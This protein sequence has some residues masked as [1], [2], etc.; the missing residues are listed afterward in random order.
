MSK[1]VEKKKNY[2][3][4]LLRIPWGIKSNSKS[5]RMVQD[6]LVSVSKIDSIGLLKK[7]QIY[8]DINTASKDYSVVG[9]DIK[10]L[11]D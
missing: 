1:A 9:N 6:Y 7:G 8:Q 2:N 11:I 5:R 3:K 4:T 10:N